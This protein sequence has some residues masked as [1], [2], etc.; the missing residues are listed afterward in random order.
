R[1]PTCSWSGSV[2]ACLPWSSW[3]EPARCRSQLPEAF[4]PVGPGLRPVAL[5]RT[6]KPRMQANC[7]MVYQQPE[8]I[9]EGTQEL[10]TLGQIRAEVD[11]QAEAEQDSREA[12]EHL[13][14]AMRTECPQAGHD[15]Q[16]EHGQH[17]ER[18][19]RR[20]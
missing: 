3:L 6:H 9:G 17:E 20:E 4:G 13:Q 11:G 7:T 2:V 19:L 10:G 16:H 14:P 5:V 8:P 1:L 18:E 15:Q 12:R